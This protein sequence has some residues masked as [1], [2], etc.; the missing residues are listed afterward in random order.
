M[1]ELQQET[2]AELDVIAKPKVQPAELDED[3]E[4]DEDEEEMEYDDEGPLVDPEEIG[5]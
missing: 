1:P 4:D 5:R 3:L 2:E